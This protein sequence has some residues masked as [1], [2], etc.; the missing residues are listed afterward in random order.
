[1]VE[2]IQAHRRSAEPWAF[3]EF[4]QRRSTTYCFHQH[5][6]SAYVYQGRTNCRGT[7]IWQTISP[8]EVI[9]DPILLMPGAA[10]NR[11][12]VLDTL[13]VDAVSQGSS[14][15]V[16]TTSEATAK[17]EPLQ[18][19]T[20]VVRPCRQRLKNCGRGH[21]GARER[22]I[23]STCLAQW[24]CGCIGCIKSCGCQRRV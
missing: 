9:G 13:D 4:E 11:F 15:P 6:A 14:S 18:K 24:H 2:A 7:G 17:S 23:L 1:M 10:S 5:C 21:R 20:L 22:V 12:G 8:S 3:F 19:E 16:D